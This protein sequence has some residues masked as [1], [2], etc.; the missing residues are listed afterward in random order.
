[1]G[2]PEQSI[3]NKAEPPQPISAGD[4]FETETV[5]ESK[6][7]GHG[8]FV[9][10]YIGDHT[11][12]TESMMGPWFVTHG[13]TAFDVRVGL[14]L[15]NFMAVLSWRFHRAP[16]AVRVPQTMYNQLERVCGAERVPLCALANGLM[17]CSL[18]RAVGIPFHLKMP[19]LNDRFPNSTGWIVAV[20]VVGMVL[21]LIAAPGYMKRKNS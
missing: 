7:N 19:R 17:F 12:G 8:S 3:L 6:L 20:L 1:M 18:A 9:G 15:G 11:L 14:L 13:V 21:W 2:M 5:P 16:I 4:E 10:T